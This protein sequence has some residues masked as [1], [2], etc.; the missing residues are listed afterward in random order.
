MNF[1]K[2]LAFMVKQPEKE[3]FQDQNYTADL[4]NC[5]C[6]PFLNGK[7]MAKV[8]VGSR[9]TWIKTEEKKNLLQSLP[10]FSQNFRKFLQEDNRQ[11]HGPFYEKNFSTYYVSYFNT[12]LVSFSSLDIFPLEN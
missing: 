9:N 5:L 8:S 4:W 7:D 10:F 3:K 1:D 2:F 11:P 6:V 12:L